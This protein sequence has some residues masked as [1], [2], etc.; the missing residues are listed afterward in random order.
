MDKLAVGLLQDQAQRQVRGVRVSCVDIGAYECR[1]WIGVRVRM[2]M[3]VE[4]WY[5]GAVYRLE[6]CDCHLTFYGLSRTA[7]PK[8]TH[9]ISIQLSANF[10]QEVQPEVAAQIEAFIERV[11]AL[12]A[13]ATPFSIVITDLSGNSFVDNPLAPAADPDITVET[14][15]RTREQSEAIGLQHLEQQAADGSAVPG[16][17]AGEGAEGA[18]GAAVDGASGEPLEG[19]TDEIQQDE[20]LHIP[21]NCPSCLVRLALAHL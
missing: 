4:M 2:R 13:G 18:E 17:H 19:V 5:E 15:Y 8:F 6:A 7:F 10:L 14:F 20:I 9:I 12:Q 1:V 3:R 11:R 16:R 21:S